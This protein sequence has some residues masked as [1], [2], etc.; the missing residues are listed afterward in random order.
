MRSGRNEEICIVAGQYRTRFILANWM[1][2][3]D[4]GIPH[5]PIYPRGASEDILEADLPAQ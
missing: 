3:I 4:M 1:G 5:H 2:K